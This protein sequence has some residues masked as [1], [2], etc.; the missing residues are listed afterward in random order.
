[1]SQR[2][3]MKSQHKVARRTSILAATTILGLSVALAG[4]GSVDDSSAADSGSKDGT[5]R[6]AYIQ[7][8]GDQQYFIDQAQGAADMAKEL[9]AEVTA[10]NVGDDANEAISQLDTVIAQGYDAVA[11]VVPDQKIGP[12]VIDAAKKAGIPLVATDDAISD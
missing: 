3:T 11:I 5:I 10:I 2:S 8:Q 1:M 12:Q 4:C 9:G 6:I 7:K